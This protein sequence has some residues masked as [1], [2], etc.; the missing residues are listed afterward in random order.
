[1]TL[2]AEKDKEVKSIQDYLARKNIK[3]VQRTTNGTFYQITVPG[4]GPKADSGKYVSIKYTGYNFDGAPFDSNEDSTKQ[5]IRHPLAPFQFRAGVS[6]AI[7]GMVDAITGFKKG[8]K[9]KMYVPSMLGYGP[10]GSPPAIKPFENLMFD[11]EVVEVS[12]TA[13]HPQG[14]GAASITPEQLQKLREQM[15]KNAQGQKKN[16]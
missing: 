9:G 4:N 8:D 3:D 1:K 11:I 6:G 12:D 13:E 14:S 10:Q 16:K 15:E 7:P 5:T 2:E